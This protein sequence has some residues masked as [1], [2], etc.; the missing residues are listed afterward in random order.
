MQL[1]ETVMTDPSLP[2]PFPIAESID[3]FVATHPNL[4]PEFDILAH[5]IKALEGRVDDLR[6]ILQVRNW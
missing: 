2:G 4:G 1:K 3:R 5:N 6:R